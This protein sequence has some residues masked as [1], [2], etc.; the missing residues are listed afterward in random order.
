VD[1]GERL[2]G[3]VEPAGEPPGVEPLGA[4][5]AARY[6]ARA[7]LARDPQAAAAALAHDACLITPGGTEV[8]GRE[9]IGAVLSQLTA[10]SQRLEIRSGRTV[11][12]GGVALCTQLWRRGGQGSDYRYSTMA[13]L[14]LAQVR[15][16]WKI[17]I[18][19]PWE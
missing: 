10:S 1:E 17:V 14:V 7:L 18:V 13:R 15:G 2:G 9:Q 3:K 12:R 4:E 16:G 6:F 11:V 8:V 19:S 5:A